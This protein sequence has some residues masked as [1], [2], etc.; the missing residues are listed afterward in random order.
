MILVT[1]LKEL[2]SMM[3]DQI[4]VC[5]RSIVIQ[6]FVCLEI[7]FFGVIC[8]RW[9]DFF[10]WYVHLK[11]SITWWRHYICAHSWKTLVI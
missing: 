9:L 10:N 7:I 1:F 2:I 6:T 3:L 5:R 4:T 8:E 11:M